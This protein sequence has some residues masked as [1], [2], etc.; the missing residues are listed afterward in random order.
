VVFLSV[1]AE[2]LG[3]PL[4][5]TPVL[6]VAGA[7]ARAGKL[8]AALVVLL[9]TFAALI[10]DLLWYELGRV[11]GIKI[12][13]LLCRISLE[14]D[15]CVRRT[16][17]AFARHGARA[18]LVAKF[19]PGVSALATPLAG[20]NGVPLPLFISYDAAGILLWIGGFTFV[21][22][23][24]SDQLA[25]LIAYSSRYGS[26]FVV[27]IVICLAAYI[28]WKFIQRKRFLRSLRVAR[29]TPGELKAKIDHGEDVMIVDLRHALDFKNDPRIIPGA[30]RLAAED[31]DKRSQEIPND[32]EL[33][34]YCS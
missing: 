4:P 10:A 21:G 6:L 26:L 11:R 13:Q 5:S 29:I 27:A 24:F 32:R 9:A 18:L 33:I 12:L 30:L 28:S 23:I 34:L 31:I 8:N 15:Y 19:V 7:L 2:Q 14:P 17:N 22:Y 25:D 1:L 20:I 16:E 3:L